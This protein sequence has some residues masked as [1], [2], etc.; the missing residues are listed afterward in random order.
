MTEK[1]TTN[2]SD[3][4]L[5]VVELDGSLED[6]KPIPPYPKGRWPG[7]VIGIEERTSAKENDYYNIEFQINRDD[8][9]PDF[10]TEE[11][12]YPDGCSLYYSRL[13]KPTPKDKR[14]L[15]RIKKFYAALG[16]DTNITA[17]NPNT[18]MGRDV[19]LVV[20]HESYEGEPRAVIKSIE[21]SDI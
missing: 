19:T 13:M 6:V 16:L 17:I 5:D 15:N 20:D 14:T 2:M 18:W 10:D 8:F 3:D 9:P 12:D 7:V 1:G 21:A 11:E 4:V